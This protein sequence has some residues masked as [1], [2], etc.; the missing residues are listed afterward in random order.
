MAGTFIA[1]RVGEVSYI[2]D[3]ATEVLK[4]LINPA[5]MTTT[6]ISLEDNAVNYQVP[7]NLTFEALGML[8]QTNAAAKT[9]TLYSST[10]ADG[11]V[12]EVDLAIIG[13]PGQT[14][15][16]EFWVSLPN[17]PTWAEDLFVNVKTSNATNS[18]TIL[19]V[20]GVEVT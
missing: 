12:G 19:A 7:S 20:I 15:P 4:T 6:G 17:K 14:N 5:V 16:T 1:T 8:I 9:L 13:L 11:V 3:S 2:V 18:A 10:A